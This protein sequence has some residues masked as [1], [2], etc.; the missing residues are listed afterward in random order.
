MFIFRPI[1]AAGPTANRAC[2]LLSK[3]MYVSV[4]PATSK[5]KLL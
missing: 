4:L 1:V 3:S 2:Q 5:P